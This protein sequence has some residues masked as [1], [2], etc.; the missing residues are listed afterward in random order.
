MD[1]RM[2]ELVHRA[3]DGEC[4]AAE[5]AELESALQKHPELREFQTRLQQLDDQ[6]RSMPEEEA[7]KELRP[8]I[9]ASIRDQ[10]SRQIRHAPREA[11]AGRRRDVAFFAAGMAAMFLVGLGILNMP[12]PGRDG[13]QTVG[14][15][16]SIDSPET[17]PIEVG[18]ETLGELRW[19]GSGDG[20]LF[21]IQWD[22]EA[23]AELEL[24]I[25]PEAPTLLRV[26]TDGRETSI[27]LAEST[28]SGR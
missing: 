3:F 20:T 24:E 11:M 2:M 13:A 28:N 16:L 1:S 8:E 26:R 25:D 19:G 21:E 14:S 27:P 12:L 4:T 15:L 6:L 10:E 23:P 5:R 17:R 18:G 7:P 22:A 9:L